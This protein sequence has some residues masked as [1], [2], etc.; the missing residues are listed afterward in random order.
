M[1]PGSSQTGL[2]SFPGKGKPFFSEDDEDKIVMCECS[3]VLFTHKGK[4]TKIKKNIF[5]TCIYLLERQSDT[6]IYTY[7][8][9]HTHIFNSL[10]D[11]S[12]DKSQGLAREKP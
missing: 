3:K 10:I 11:S 2:G 8:H 1:S 12:C 6:L 5:Q 4:N 7:S 9:T